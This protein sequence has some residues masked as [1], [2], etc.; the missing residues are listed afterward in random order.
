MYAEELAVG[1]SQLHIGTQ[2]LEN[3]E[4]EELCDLI[5]NDADQ[6][7]L[8]ED[9]GPAPVLVRARFIAAQRGK[10]TP[11]RTLR[12]AHPTLRI[13]SRKHDELFFY[14]YHANFHTNLCI[15]SIATAGGVP[16]PR[17]LTRC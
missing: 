12:I 10:Y 4:M 5:L 8:Q 11:H 7:A 14:S 3:G 13:A 2:E 17:T 6:E 1:G 16:T 15:C 9:Q